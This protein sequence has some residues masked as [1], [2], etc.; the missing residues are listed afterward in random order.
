LVKKIGASLLAAAYIF[1]GSSQIAAANINNA[2]INQGAAINSSVNK[3]ATASIKSVR[4]NNSTAKLRIVYEVGESL[5]Y[6]LTNSSDG[7][8]VYLDITGTA[9]ANLPSNIVVSDGTLNGV[10]F[11]KTP[12][13]LRTVISLKHSVNDGIKATVSRLNNP[14]RIYIDIEKFF[15]EKFVD[16]P[17]DGLT[18][19]KFVRNNEKGM[20]TAYFLEVAPEKGLSVKPILA[21]G[22]ILGR[23]SLSAMAARSHAVAAVNSSYFASDGELLGFTKID[24][25]IAST[26]YIKRG[27][28]GINSDETFFTGQVEY[29]GTAAAGGRTAYLSGVNCERGENGAVLYNKYWG[30]STGTNIYGKEYAVKNNVVVAIY[31]SNAPLTD[32]VKVLSVHGASAELFKDVKVGDSL[33]ITENVSLPW[34]NAACAVGVGPLLV[35]GGQIYLTTSEESFGPDV[36]SGRAPRTAAGVLS[37][38]HLLLAIVDGRQSHSIGCTLSEMAALMK[39]FGAV[40]AV[41]FDGGGSTEMIVKNRIVNSP[42]D[43]GERR[44]GA[45]LGVFVK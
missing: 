13:G 9:A 15:E 3:E 26:T 7:K 36:A 11:L 23:E 33:V 39:E 25:E 32:G 40:E 22:K 45:G 17:Q 42:S 18:Y 2:N 29:S 4:Y 31:N 5:D 16:S 24:G 43:G 27:A 8:T 37:N 19:T 14:T 1:I 28:L 44:V 34:Q 20:L 6:K 35:R 10:N 30:A 21:Q 41:N 38:G 12:T